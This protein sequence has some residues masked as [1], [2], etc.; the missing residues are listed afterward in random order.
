MRN[1]V[2]MEYIKLEEFRKIDPKSKCLLPS[3][4][5][6]K[7]KYDAH[8]RFITKLKSCSVAGRHKQKPEMYGRI[9]SP[10]VAL[11]HVM[12]C[13]SLVKKLKARLATLN[14]A[15]AF[16]YAKLDEEIYDSTSRHRGVP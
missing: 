10:T 4:I 14:V 7:G 16:L 15:A 11:S 1:H 5:F 12:I 9:L 6:L 2:V 3:K 8:G 13:I